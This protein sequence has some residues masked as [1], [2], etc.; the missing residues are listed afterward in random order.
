MLPRKQNTERW[1]T[2]ARC[3]WIIF[4]CFAWC[5]PSS[6][7]LISTTWWK[8]RATIFTSLSN[9]LASIVFAGKRRRSHCILSL[10]SGRSLQNNMR[11]I[12]RSIFSVI[13]S[14]FFSN[15]ENW[16]FLD[17]FYFTI[18][19]LTT[20]GFGDLTPSTE[21]PP[22]NTFPGRKKWQNFLI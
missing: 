17:A 1:R 5:T 19:T 15:I 14:F 3:E 21:F 9:R 6:A 7:C 13:P 8:S 2:V 10:D 4:R 16:E 12:F 22:N 18:I 11:L 20:I